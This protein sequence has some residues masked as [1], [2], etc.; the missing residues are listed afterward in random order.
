MPDF[1]ALM[2]ASTTLFEKRIHNRRQTSPERKTH[3]RKN[4]SISLAAGLIMNTESPK[5]MGP[6]RSPRKQIR[7]Q[8]VERAKEEYDEGGSLFYAYALRVC[9]IPRRRPLRAISA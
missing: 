1:T 6:P 9:Y 5:G 3:L 7:D 4:P 8:M 2:D